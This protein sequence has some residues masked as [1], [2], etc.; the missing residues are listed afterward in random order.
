MSVC[1]CVS[2]SKDHAEVNVTL[3]VHQM[4]S[5]IN[6]PLTNISTL[7]ESVSSDLGLHLHNVGVF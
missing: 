4:V 6:L 1:V 3:D 7:L 2:Y 5:S